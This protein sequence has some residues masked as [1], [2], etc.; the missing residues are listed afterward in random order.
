MDVPNVTFKIE[1]DG[2][3]VQNEIYEAIKDDKI[4]EDVWNKVVPTSD[5]DAQRF[6]TDPDYI[7]PVVERNS[8]LI[9]MYA[10]GGSSGTIS[11]N[12][13]GSGTP[14]LDDGG[15]GPPGSTFGGNGGGGGGPGDGSNGGNGGDSRRITSEEKFALKGRVI[16]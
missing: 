1:D 16:K 11:R 8:A 12:T 3:T 2:V 10:G 7:A 14:V 9:E 6:F 5:F 13:G 15:N 4:L